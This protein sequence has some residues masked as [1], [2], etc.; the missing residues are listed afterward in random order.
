MGMFEKSISMQMEMWEFKIHILVGLT[1]FDIK[2]NSK[3]PLIVLVLTVYETD[4]QW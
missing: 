4:L 3:Y 2:M 1:L